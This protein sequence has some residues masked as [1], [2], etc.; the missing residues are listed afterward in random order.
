MSITS[1]RY[2]NFWTHSELITFEYLVG[3]ININYIVPL[4][5]RYKIYVICVEIFRLLRSKPIRIPHWQAQYSIGGDG[6]V[7]IHGRDLPHS[8]QAQSAGLLLHGRQDRLHLSAADTSAC[9]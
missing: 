3:I 9:E 1:K 2:H 7:H 4:F 8:V 5:C 6:A